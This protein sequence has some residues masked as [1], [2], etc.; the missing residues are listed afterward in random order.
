[1]NNEVGVVENSE[2]QVSN[3]HNNPGLFKPGQ[4]G[5]PKGRPLKEK[6]IS[7]KLLKFLRDDPAL[8][9]RLAKTLLDL[10]LEKKDLSAIREIIDRLEGKAIQPV[11]HG[12]PDGED[13][14]IQLMRYGDKHPV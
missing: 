10:A 12:G 3:R 7:D 14:V 2:I 6:L 5:N 11:A 1:M 13:L 9:E 8:L 4:S